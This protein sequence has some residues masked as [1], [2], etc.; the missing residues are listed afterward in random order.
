MSSACVLVVVLA[1]FVSSFK[2]KPGIVP[3]A[4][5]TTAVPAAQPDNTANNVADA[6]FHAWVEERQRQLEDAQAAQALAGSHQPS[7]GRP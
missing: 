3:Q 1:G 7:D 4:Q 5:A 2:K 6:P